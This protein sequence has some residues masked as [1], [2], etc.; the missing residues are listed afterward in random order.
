MAQWR[1]ARVLRAA[2]R[3]WVGYESGNRRD[4]FSLGLTKEFSSPKPTLYLKG[5]YMEKI[6]IAEAGNTLAPALA[7]LHRLGYTVIKLDSASGVLRAE[8]DRFQLHAADPLTLLG[9][10]YL[11][12]E[13][14]HHWTATDEEITRYFAL[15]GLEDNT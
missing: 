2:L 5:P 13:R 6:S 1:T 10:A 4:F 9:L 12:Q 14:G 15:E 7:V 11:A 8:N 3:V